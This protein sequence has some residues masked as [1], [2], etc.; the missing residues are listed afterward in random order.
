MASF[1][2]Q[3]L[4]EAHRGWVS[5]FLDKHWGSAL[6]VS[7]G[8]LIDAAELPGFVAIQNDQLVG[9]ATYQ[10]RGRECELVSLNSEVAG[11]G[12]GSA[13]VTA[14]MDKAIAAGCRR[15]WLITTND[16][17]PALGFYQKRGFHLVAVHP[18]ALAQ[19][20]KL[21]PHIPSIGLDGIPLRDELELEMRLD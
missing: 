19:S 2:I 21:K 13:L 17:L 12:I 1:S 9:L 16:N 10:V 7:R 3:P 11:E 5:R 18:G 6:V 14:V 20:R 8:K 15:L 4:E